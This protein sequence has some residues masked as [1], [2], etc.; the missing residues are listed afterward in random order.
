MMSL[1][2][3]LFCKSQEHQR[4]NKFSLLIFIFSHRGLFISVSLSCQPQNYI[5]HFK[6]LNA[7]TT[8]ASCLTQKKYLAQSPP[9]ST[10]FNV[11]SGYQVTAG[12]KINFSLKLG[13]LSGARLRIKRCFNIKGFTRRLLNSTLKAATCSYS[14]QKSGMMTLGSSWHLI[15]LCDVKLNNSWLNNWVF[16]VTLLSQSCSFPRLEVLLQYCWY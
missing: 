13:C 14:Y 6:I 15:V 3:I 9:Q 2:T 7:L 1:L 11:V 8:V 10:Q 16:I 5:K 12:G 4:Y